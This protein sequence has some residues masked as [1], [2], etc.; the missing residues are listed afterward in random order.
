LPDCILRRTIACALRQA[1]RVAR[2]RCPAAAGVPAPAPWAADSRQGPPR[3]RGPGLVRPASV[4][5]W[6]IAQQH[7]PG[8]ALC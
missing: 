3:V 8:V 4:G 2:L 1:G 7:A 6:L 5:A